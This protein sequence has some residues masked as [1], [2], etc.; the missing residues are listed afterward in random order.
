MIVTDP[1]P[2]IFQRFPMKIAFDRFEKN[3]IDIHTPNA[4]DI[5]CP[6]QG[7]PAWGG[8]GPETETIGKLFCSPYFRESLKRGTIVNQL[9]FGP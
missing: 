3:G 1:E 5:T 4:M 8:S 9:W 6:T 7:I 2:Q